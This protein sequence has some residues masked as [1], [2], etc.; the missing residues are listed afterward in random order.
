MCMQ[1]KYTYFQYYT[2][3][4]RKLSGFNGLEIVSYMCFKSIS[5]KYVKFTSNLSVAHQ[6]FLF[7]RA[8]AVVAPHRHIIFVASE[9]HDVTNLETGIIHPLNGSCAKKMSCVGFTTLCIL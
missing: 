5:V 9:I 1:Q 2:L 3:Y 6:L 4:L 8:M 7:S